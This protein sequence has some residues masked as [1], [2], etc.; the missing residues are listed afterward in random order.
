MC[1]RGL[2]RSY[3]WSCGSSTRLSLPLKEQ[4]QL[5]GR[6]NKEQ[7]SRC[8]RRSPPGQGGLRGPDRK[9]SDRGQAE[10]QPARDLWDHKV[11][12]GRASTLL[13][14]IKNAIQE[15]GA[16]RRA[17]IRCI[18]GISP[19]RCAAPR[20]SVSP[21]QPNESPLE[22]RAPR[23]LPTP[24]RILRSKCSDQF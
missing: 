24:A 2:G 7:T 4:P 18:Y 8:A 3:Y 1:K 6:A 22:M 13:R 20:R 23:G 21:G 17:M 19:F 10:E 11:S 14:G 5:F 12:K 9:R 16:G 15:L